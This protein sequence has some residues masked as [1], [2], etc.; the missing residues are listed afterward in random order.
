M[1]KYQLNGGEDLENPIFGGNPYV[2]IAVLILIDIILIP[3]T[4]KKLLSG[5][6]GKKK[7]AASIVAAAAVF[8]VID[9]ICAAFIIGNSFSYDRTGKRYDY[10]EPVIYYTSEGG[11]FTLNGTGDG[12]R[13][14][15]ANGTESYLAERVYVDDDGFLYFDVKNEL[16]GTKKDGTFTDADGKKYYRADAVEWNKY[17]DM[18]LKKTK[19][20]D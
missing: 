9:C 5:K 10:N 1:L 8:I 16:A 6:S 7:K 4:V 13:F 17:G 14:A 19:G 15:N 11:K 20:T 18:S 2:Y 12:A 3:L